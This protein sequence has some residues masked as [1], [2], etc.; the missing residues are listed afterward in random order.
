MFSK[1]A[2]LRLSFLE[3]IA[4]LIAAG[5]APDRIRIGAFGETRATGTALDCRVEIWIEP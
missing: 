2:K 4:L 5:I 1:E 3:A